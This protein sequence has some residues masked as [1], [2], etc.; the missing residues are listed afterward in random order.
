MGSQSQVNLG[1]LRPASTQGQYN[2]IMFAV[3]QALAKV[4]TATLV[5]IVACTND[6]DV[7]PVGTVD[8]L[9]LVNQ[10]DGSNPPNPTEHVTIY[11]LPY[12]RVLGG[13][14][15]I[16]LDPKPGDIGVAV[17]ANR[18]ISKVKSTRDQA[19]PGS[20]RQ[21][22][23]A[24][25]IYLGGLLNGAPQQ[26]IQF[27]DAGIKIIAPAITAGENAVPVLSEPFLTWVTSKLLPTLAAK[28]IVVAPPPD[29]SLTSVFEAA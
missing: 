9:P 3:Q 16:I 29:N 24:D 18:D 15:A 19:N 4:Q 25:G 17:F 2:N 13:E 20:F 28:G 6:G 5:K 26:Y 23:F 7:S 21:F 27:S 14:S 8:V 11:G 1:A 22:D 10:I 12:L